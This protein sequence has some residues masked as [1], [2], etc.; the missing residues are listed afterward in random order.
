[1]NDQKN[2]L[3][4]ESELFAKRQAFSKETGLIFELYDKRSLLLFWINFCSLGIGMTNQVES[5]IKKAGENCLE[6]GFSEMG[7]LLIKHAKQEKGHELLMMKDTENLINLW[8]TYFNDKLDLSV[9]KDAKDQSKSVKN[10]QDLHEEIINGPHPYAQIAI[11]YEIENLSI[12][13]GPKIL[14][15]TQKILGTQIIEHLSFI[16]HHIA[17]DE[18]HTNFNRQAMTRFLQ[19]NPSS[20]PILIDTGKKA[21]KS[22]LEYLLEAFEMTSKY[23]KCKEDLLAI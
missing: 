20:L 7:K 8:N 14:M 2:F 22:Y 19:K 6:K 10:Y 4:Y 13:Y 23:I 3:N 12:E 15:H 18:G 1:M 11:E 17:L 21:L 16:E 9:F 5:F